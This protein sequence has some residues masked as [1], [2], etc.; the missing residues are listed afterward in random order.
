M[1]KQ[2]R[3]KIFHEPCGDG[4]QR[5][6]YPLPQIEVEALQ[7]NVCRAVRRRY[8]RRF[9]IV[10][11]VN[12][13][14]HSLNSLYFGRSWN[15]GTT[16][17]DLDVLPQSQRECLHE[18][19]RKVRAFGPLPPGATRQGA[20]QALRAPSSGYVVEPAAGVGEVTNM[21]LE[22]LSKWLV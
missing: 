18:L 16:V 10:K 4:R 21:Q 5:D 3:S 20:L 13:A 6:V 1:V 17:T 8:H 7:G 14:I 12:R 9:A 19:I 11:M 2:W 15:G 22:R